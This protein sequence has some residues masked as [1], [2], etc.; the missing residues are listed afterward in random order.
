[1]QDSTLDEVI[2]FI[3]THRYNFTN[4]GLATKEE[5]KRGISLC[6]AAIR[7]L[8]TYKK[9]KEVLPDL[10]T[11]DA[12]DG[13]ELVQVSDIKNFFKTEEEKIKL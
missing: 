13:E 10:V 1:M 5:I 4:S 7:I 8:K 6:G 9:F 12:P 2:E 3:Q 11:W